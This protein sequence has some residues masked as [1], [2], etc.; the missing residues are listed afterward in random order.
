M[1]DDIDDADVVSLWRPQPGPQH[2]MM[3]CPTPEIFFGGARGGG[4]TD[5]TLGRLNHD[6]LK[7][8]KGFNALFCRLELPMLDD[9]IERSRDIFGRSGASYIE[10]KKTWIWGNGARLRFRPLERTQDADKYQGQN[11]SHAVIE[12]A[13]LYKNSNA[14]DRLN[15]VLRSA[16]GIPTQMFLTGNPGG[17]GQ[18]WIKQRF[19]DPCPAGMTPLHYQLPNGEMHT[20]IFIPSKVEDNL[21]LMRNDPKYINRL[22]MAGSPALVDAWLKGSWDAIEGAF[23]DCWSASKHVCRPFQIP[24]SWA[25]FRSADWGSA[26]PFSVGWWAVVSEPTLLSNGITAPRG[27]MIRY[28]E[29]YG[30][31]GTP[32][33]GL[34]MTAEAVGAGIYKRDQLDPVKSMHGVLDPA[35]FSEDGGPSIAERMANE[36]AFF[37]PADNKRVTVNGRNVGAMGGWDTMRQRLIGNDPLED[38]QGRLIEVTEP[39]LFVF[40]TCRDFIRTVPALQHDEMRPEDLDTD[41]E[42]HIADEVRYA[43]MSRP[44]TRTLK[45]ERSKPKTG[46]KP[47]RS[48]DTGNTASW[49][50]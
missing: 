12:E 8:G 37:H 14:I 13:G 17:A 49:R 44:F 23:F 4:K 19:I 27:A 25:R 40:D 42:D 22:Y 36:K 21:V 33:V 11:V 7:Y 28:R 45:E 18:Q 31:N 10:H 30:S 26:K 20:R 47:M 34:K 16:T 48:A 9:A 24:D 5:G 6:A 43:C 50:T 46:Y 35:A 1:T 15:G 3:M 32:N 41:Q 38:E 2:A 29:W 39:M